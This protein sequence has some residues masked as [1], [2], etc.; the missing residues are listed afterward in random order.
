MSQT[1][2]LAITGL[3]ASIYLVMK[4]GSRGWAIAAAVTSAVLTA[5]GL[6]LVQLSVSSLPLDVALGGVL[7]VAGVMLFMKVKD[8][9]AIASA[10]VVTL[11][12]AV[13]VLAGLGII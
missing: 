7:G 5:I 1:T 6:G 8:K 9:F 12:A 13:L 4:S 3:V 10:T 2:V 11:V